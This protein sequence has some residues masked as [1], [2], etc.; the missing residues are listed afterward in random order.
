VIMSKKVAGTVDSLEPEFLKFH[1][2][3]LG[4][5][6]NGSVNDKTLPG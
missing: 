5:L 1:F 4:V 2:L 6:G 3:K